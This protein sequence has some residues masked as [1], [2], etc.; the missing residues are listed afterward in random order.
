MRN[1]KQNGSSVCCNG[2]CAHIKYGPFY[3]SVIIASTE[4]IQFLFHGEMVRADAIAH[5][6]VLSDEISEYKFVKVEEA[7]PLLSERLG[8]RIRKC[9]EA[10]KK[11]PGLYLEDAN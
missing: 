3:F 2:P 11:G 7:V 6:N 1:T 10:F 4:S 8:R 5:N 9:L